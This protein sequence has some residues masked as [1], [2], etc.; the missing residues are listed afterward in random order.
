MNP[1]RN[2]AM[3]LCVA[4]S[5]PIKGD[6]EQNIEHHQR[7]ID[8]AVAHQA[9][10]VIFPELSITG[11][12]P[13]LAKQLATT[14]DDSRFDVFQSI[15]DAKNIIIGI[16]V[17]IKNTAGVCISMVLFHPRAARLIYSKKYIHADE[18]PFFISGKNLSTVIADKPNVA[19]AIC[20]ELSIPEHAA[21]AASSGANIYLASVVKTPKQ[22]EGA[23]ARLAAIARQYS[24]TVLMANCVGECD[25]A[26][27]G[28]SSSVWNNQGV[29]LG[30]LDAASEG[31]L[32]L[33]TDT[34]ELTQET[35]RTTVS[36]VP[37]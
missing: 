29:L 26:Q 17:P 33:D 36:S 35:V 32:M 15:A 9:D 1:G 20:Y 21:Q 28:G 13:T 3:E 11:Y 7:L 2:N 27:C 37:I 31:I 6:I 5:R 23:T 30:Q 22:L 19:L 16:G 24:M 10:I 8:R 4:Q 12:E 18:E 14:A 25:G 34:Q